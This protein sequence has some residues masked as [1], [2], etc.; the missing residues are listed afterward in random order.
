VAG[1]DLAPPERVPLEDDDFVTDAE[2]DALLQPWR[3]TDGH[4][5]V[6]D[7]FRGTAAVFPMTHRH[8][9]SDRADGT[10]LPLDR[11][12]YGGAGGQG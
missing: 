9:A 11:L 10:P 3:V 6:L 2:R 4:G 1:S 5:R 8:A 7:R 12:A